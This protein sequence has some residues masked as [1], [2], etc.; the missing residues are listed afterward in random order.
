MSRMSNDESS[1][2][3]STEGRKGKQ[4]PR[5]NDSYFPGFVQ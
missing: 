5:C 1:D 4:C 2:S 3:L